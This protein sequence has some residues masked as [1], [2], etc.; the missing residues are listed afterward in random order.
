M[1]N[2]VTVGIDRLK[3]LPLSYYPLFSPDSSLLLCR[4]VRILH[5]CTILNCQYPSQLACLHH[6]MHISSL[7]YIKDETLFV[8]LLALTFGAYVY[9]YLSCSLVL[10]RD[11]AIIHDGCLQL[12]LFTPNCGDTAAVQIIIE[13]PYYAAESRQA[14][15]S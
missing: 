12:Y 4:L 3:I 11:T 6:N 14:L 13:I 9:I 15:R 1:Y 7:A 5:T 8:A 10:L 2:I